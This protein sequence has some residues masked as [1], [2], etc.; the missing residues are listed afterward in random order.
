MSR[1]KTIFWSKFWKA[2]T[3]KPEAAGRRLIFSTRKSLPEVKQSGLDNIIMNYDL[4][5]IMIYDI[6]IHMYIQTFCGGRAG[7]GGV[8]CLSLTSCRKLRTEPGSSGV[9]WSGQPRKW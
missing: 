2:I 7:G 1:L 3:Q 4:N 9:P 8:T 6:H 5:I